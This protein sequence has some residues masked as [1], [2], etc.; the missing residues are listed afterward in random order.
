MNQD[1][2][3]RQKDE[4]AARRGPGTTRGDV[5]QRRHGNAHVQRLVAEFHAL[6]LENP[7]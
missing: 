3:D 1:R 2:V 5:L 7:A 6:S 4:S